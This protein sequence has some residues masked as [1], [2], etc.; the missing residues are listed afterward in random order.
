MS[1]D[2]RDPEEDLLLD[3]DVDLAAINQEPAEKVFFFFLFS[4]L[5]SL[6]FSSFAHLKICRKKKNIIYFE[7]FPQKAKE[8]FLCVFVIKTLK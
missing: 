2:R 3:V 5:F 8:L 7:F 1:V 4:S 6:L